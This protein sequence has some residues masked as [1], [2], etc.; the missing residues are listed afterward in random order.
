MSSKAMV[1]GASG[2]LGRRL[3]RRLLSQ[4]RKIVCVDYFEDKRA[5]P[6]FS[7]HN[8]QLKIVNGDIRN[9][10]SFADEFRGCETV[11]NCAGIQHPCFTSDIYSVNR[12]A[13]AKLLESCIR[14]NVKNLVH[15]STAIVHGE[16][17]GKSMI[18]EKTL[19]RPL[20]HY[21]VSK[22]QGEELL[23]K[24][25][26]KAKVKIVII[27]PAAFYGVHPSRNLIEFVM[28]IKKNLAIVFGDQ[29][30]LRTYVDIEKVVDAMLL[31]EKH[32]RHCEAY[33]IGDKHPISALQLHQY[34]ADELGVDL[35]VRHL[36]VSLSRLCEKVSF[37]AGRLNVHL[38]IPNIIGEFG[39]N[40]Y[41]SSE[42]AIKE[43]AYKPHDSPE[44]GLKAM[45]RSVVNR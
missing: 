27:R 23:V 36:P 45:T 31:A 38:R 14:S 4:K 11:F 22:I 37:T 3:I 15:I 21:A 10:E 20:T 30:A 39:R 28:N 43:L 7:K 32:G 13:P 2:W 25:G 44:K 35:R 26:G 16:N 1:T 24:I 29:G 17:V 42:K 40:Q 19:C 41:F 33:L 9:P 6:E 18:T 5:L 12:D 34:I 8:H